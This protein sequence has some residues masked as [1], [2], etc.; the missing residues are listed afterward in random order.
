MKIVRL[1]ECKSCRQKFPLYW[2]NS[3]GKRVKSNKRIYCFSCSPHISKNERKAKYVNTECFCCKKSLLKREREIS[4]SGCVY[5]SKSCAAKINNQKFQKRHKTKK[6][7]N[8]KCNNLV[9]SSRT[10][11]KTCYE[12]YM[13]KNNIQDF[14]LAAFHHKRQG[15]NKYSE[16]R[17]YARKTYEKS[18]KPKT[19]LICGYDR[20]IEI[21]HLKAISSFPLKTTIKTINKLSNLI[22]LCPNHHKEVDKGIIKKQEIETLIKNFNPN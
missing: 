10:Y 17:H 5:C 14:T 11:C 1:G 16:I 21:H 22:P 20:Y 7:K 8:N 9:A 4:I 3:D 18:N 13:Q 12:D 19:C 15:A 6:C 2:K